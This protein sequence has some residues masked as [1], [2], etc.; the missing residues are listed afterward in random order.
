M[1][2]F[3]FPQFDSDNNAM[4]QWQQPLIALLAVKGND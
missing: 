4:L 3:L 2:S 1:F